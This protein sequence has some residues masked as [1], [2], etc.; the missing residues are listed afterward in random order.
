MP[1]VLHEAPMELL[2]RSPQLAAVLLRDLGITVPPHANAAMASSDLTAILPAELRADAVI[3][4]SAASRPKLAVVIEVQRRYDKGKTYTW[5]AYLTQVRAARHCPAILLVICPSPATA[6]L[7]R[8]PITTGHPGFDL[9][10]L[11]IDAATLRAPDTLDA[12]AAAPELTVLAVLTGALN[13]DRDDTR[14]LVLDTLATL[15][16][17]RLATYTVFIRAA[18]SPQAR[19]ALEDLMTTRYKDDFVDRLLAEG[20]AKGKAEGEAKG[21][22]EGEAKG[23]AEGE[24][25]IVLRILAARGL[26]VPTDIRQRVLSCADTSQLETWADRAVTAA[27]LDDVF[28]T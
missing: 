12:A 26:E 4:F 14:R 20:E 9:I 13:L 28:S 18:A 7:Y 16:D 27:T 24:A 6:T 11:V 21:K 2:R 1:T 25:L 10:P 17:T 19:K 5:P 22:A 15:D 3:I 23:K 8:T